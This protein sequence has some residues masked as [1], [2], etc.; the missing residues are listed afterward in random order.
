MDQDTLGKNVF[1]EEEGEVTQFQFPAW[2]SELIFGL[3]LRGA[4]QKCTA[5]LFRKDFVTI[6]RRGSIRKVSFQNDTLWFL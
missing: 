4:S 2:F 3:V 6:H 5:T 1:L